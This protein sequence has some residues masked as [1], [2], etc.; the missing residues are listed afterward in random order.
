VGEQPKLLV[1]QFRTSLRSGAELA[2]RDNG[3]GVFEL[4]IEAMHEAYAI[5]YAVHHWP[6]VSSPEN[7]ARTFTVTVAK[8]LILRHA[9]PDLFNVGLRALRLW[10]SAPLVG[11]LEGYHTPWEDVYWFIEGSLYPLTKRLHPRILLNDCDSIS[12]SMQDPGLDLPSQFHA[13]LSADL[14]VRQEMGPPATDSALSHAE[15]ALTRMETL[16]AMEYRDEPGGPR[17]DATTPV[18]A[19]EF[20]EEQLKRGRRVLA[21]LGPDAKRH[22]LYRAVQMSNTRARRLFRFLEAGNGSGNGNG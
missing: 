13:I 11:K 8:F 3:A 2:R 19:E 9:S 4:A 10:P 17:T 7:L 16:Y 15:A 6:K 20:T 5:R 12:Q 14:G 21:E 18:M 22:D 1:E